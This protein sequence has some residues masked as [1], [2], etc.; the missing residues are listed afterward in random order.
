LA[1][2]WDVLWSCLAF[3][4]VVVENKKK[5]KKKEKKGKERDKKQRMICSVPCFVGCCRVGPFVACF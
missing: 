3:S 5:K 2:V 1:G 4:R